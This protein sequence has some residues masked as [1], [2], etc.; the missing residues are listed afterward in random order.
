MKRLT[1]LVAGALVLLM[2]GCT[3]QYRIESAAMQARLAQEAETQIGGYHAASVTLLERA[4][5]KVENGHEQSLLLL[6]AHLATEQ[7]LPP[8][9]D[10]AKPTAT[11][12]IQHLASTLWTSLDGVQQDRKTEAARYALLQ[13]I[14][15]GIKKIAAR[16]ATIAMRETNDLEQ[17]KELAEEALLNRFFSPV[18]LLEGEANVP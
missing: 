14:L 2:A 16:N 15:A 5:A 7:P 3:Q 12:Y 17:L 6:V 9:G 18:P 10:I 1:S 11:D 13:R 4:Q 8:L